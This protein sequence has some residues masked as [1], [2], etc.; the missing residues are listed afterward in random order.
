MKRISLLLCSLFVLSTLAFAQTDKSERKSPP[1]T[2]EGEVG[3]AKITI[4]YS[5]PAVNE[6]E[7]YGGLVPYD[8]IWRA[9]ANEATTFE[10]S[11]DL[12]VNGESLPAGKYAFFV[13]PKAEGNWTVIFNSEHKQWGAYKHDESK[14]VLRLEAETATIDPVENLTYSIQN[15]QMNLDWATKRMMLK[16]EE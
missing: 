6:R 8:K 4:A 13:I 14:D 10:T 11:T 7:I 1:A 9:G 2:A 12:K 3:S 15:D 16:L 5:S